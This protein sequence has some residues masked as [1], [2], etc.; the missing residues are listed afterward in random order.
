MANAFVASNPRQPQDI[1]ISI[2]AIMKGSWVFTPRPLTQGQ[3]SV[4]YRAA[5]ETPRIIWSSQCF[6]DAHP[7]EWRAILETI[8]AGGGKW[9]VVA[10]AVQ[11]A[12]HKARAEKQKKPSFVLGLVVPEEVQANIKHN[13]A[14]PDFLHFITVVDQCKGSIGL[15]NM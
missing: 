6:R 13:F 12:E 10:S 2:V 11:W 9:R 8:N 14:L 7:R 5:M 3:P 4:K 15:L 1:V